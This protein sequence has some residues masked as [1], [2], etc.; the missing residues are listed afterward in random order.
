MK[1]LPIKLPETASVIKEKR[2]CSFKLYDGDERRK[3]DLLTG[4]YYKVE[5][6]FRRD[7]RVNQR[8]S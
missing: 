1:I 6:R 7:R 5:K 8:R 4:H 3:K 2:R